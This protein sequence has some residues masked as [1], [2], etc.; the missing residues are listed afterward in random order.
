LF[1]SNQWKPSTRS[2]IR[3]L[4]TSSLFTK[5]QILQLFHLIVSG[6]LETAAQMTIT[7][8]R[9]IRSYK[10]INREEITILLI[11]RTSSK[12]FTIIFVPGTSG[13][14]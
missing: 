4:Q 3:I 7:L 14:K 11:Q 1:F 8:K 9:T 2:L 12:S 5:S 10:F 13:K 6:I